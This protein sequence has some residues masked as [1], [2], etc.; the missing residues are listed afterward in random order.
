MELFNA[1]LIIVSI[2]IVGGIFLK[3]ALNH[4]PDS[5]FFTEQNKEETK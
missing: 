2:I 5:Y 1:I 4:K 3:L